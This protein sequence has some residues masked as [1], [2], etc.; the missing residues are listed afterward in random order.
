MLWSSAAVLIAAAGVASA[1]LSQ[2]DAEALLQ[3]VFAERAAERREEHTD[4]FEAGTIATDA[5]DLRIMQRTFGDAD[6]GERSLWISMH[7]GGGTAARVNDQQWQNQIRLYEP[8]E[9]LYIAPRAPS[10]TWNLWHRAEIDVMFSELINAAV[11]V[12]GVDPDRVYLMGYSAGGDGVYQLGPR[13]ADR[14]AA[15]AMMA[16]HPNEAQPL[17][18]RNLPF[19]IFM[20][21]ED[22]AFN[23]NTVAKQWRDQLRELQA[24]DPDGYDHWVQIY[25]GL[26][27]WMNRRDAEALPWMAERSRDAWPARV[28][29]RQDD[30]T[31]TRFYWLGIDA[32]HAEAGDVVIAAVS[33]QTITIERADVPSLTLRLRDD[34]IDLDERVTVMLSSADGDITL[35]DGIVERTEAAVRESIAERLDRVTAA[36]ATLTVETSD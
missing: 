13:M 6:Q 4:A 21:S 5:G 30:V 9:G 8:D 3:A 2:A 32:E 1:Q 27:H 18:L 28:V 35:F 12:H 7:G 25:D 31:H 17:G 14:F 10:D 33:G 16:G 19:A 36:T 26:G 11:A 22:A 29:W 15:A 23:R 34:F 24:D 20:G